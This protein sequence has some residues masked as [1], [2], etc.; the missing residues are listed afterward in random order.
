MSGG[1]Q[2]A[3]AP[4][5]DRPERALAITAHPDDVDFG[6]A[7][8]VA[9]W[10][11]QGV[12]VSYCIV[13]DG[14]AGGQSPAVVEADL[15]AVRRAEQ[16]AAARLV[17]VH[18]VRFLGYPDG[19]LTEGL[20]LRRELSRLIRQLRPHRVLTHSPERNYRQVAF[21][22]PDH[23]VVGAAAMDAVYPD[24]RNRYAFPELLTEES[25]TEWTVEQL[26]LCG[27]PAVEVYVDI[28][29]V[30]ED[31][32]AAILAHA[33]QVGHR[34]GLAAALRSRLADAAIEAGFGAGRYAE[35]FQVV[36]TG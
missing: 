19:R 16:R 36:Q 2:A 32:L 11:R 9:N 34:D 22:H 20:P 6:C 8:T 17:G 29:E 21:S 1:L 23:R 12:E 15:A 25:L 10:V 27:G 5:G 30:I 4:A 3:P 33:S 14:A 35:G 28:T 26:W 31:K 24:A 7:G 18:D 13:T